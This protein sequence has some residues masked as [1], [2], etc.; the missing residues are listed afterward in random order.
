[1]NGRKSFW[2]ASK[3]LVTC[4]L[5]LYW[6][7][8]VS[9]S[10]SA[11]FRYEDFGPQVAVYELIGFEWWQ[12]ESHGDADP[13]VKPDI[14]VVVYW[15]EALD[16]IKTQFPVD[17]ARKQDYRYVEYEKVKEHLERLILDFERSGLNADSLRATLNRLKSLKQ[18]SGMNWNVLDK[19]RVRA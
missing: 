17:A 9:F 19:A 4:L 3:K 16:S 2:I 5:F 14:K 12:W 11:I 15:D 8:A 6:I 7:P 1:M 18:P 10:G 13:T